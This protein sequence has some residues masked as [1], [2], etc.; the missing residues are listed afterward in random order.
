MTDRRLLY[1]VSTAKYGS[2]TAAADQV[3]VTQSAVTKSVAELERE[4]GYA[5]FNR[6]ARGVFLTDQGR[7]FVERAARILDDTR[8]LFRGATTRSDPYAGVLRIGVGPASLEWLL[9]EPLS[10]LLSQ[11][12]S[13]QLDITGGSFDRIV[14]Q[15]RTGALDV[16]L[17]YEAAFETQPDFRLETLPP[18]KTSFFVRQGHPILELDE[19]DIGDIAKYD[20]ISPSGSPPYDAVWR[21]VY[22]QADAEP[23]GR[24]HVID[25]FP[26]VA[27]LVRNSN[28][29]GLVSLQYTETRIFKSR[30]AVVPYLQRLPPSSLCC[31][32]RTRWSPR[33]AVRA[34]VRACRER[35]PT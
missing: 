30:F 22:D 12:P 18:L 16:A 20:L 10:T 2:F 31:A 8:E 17:G 3:G 26:I 1:I 15:L 13:V 25:Y 19:V 5:I 29:V 7:D 35:F 34:F 24:L 9:V 33:P 11:H 21:Q 27:R 23:T 32:T 6:T 4:L 14:Q 28:A